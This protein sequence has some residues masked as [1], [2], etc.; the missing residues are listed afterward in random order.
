MKQLTLFDDYGPVLT[1]EGAHIM[2]WNDLYNF[3]TLQKEKNP[4]LF[5]ECVFVHDIETGDEYAC[6]TT[7]FS[8]NNKLVLSINSDS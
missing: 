2:T 3:L 7:V 5:N 8:D 1:I 6:D 4:T